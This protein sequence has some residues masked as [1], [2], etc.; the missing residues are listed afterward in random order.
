MADLNSTMSNVVNATRDGTLGVYGAL[1]Q[2]EIMNLT[3]FL[4]VSGSSSGNNG[5]V[6]GGN[7]VGCLNRF[8][9]QLGSALEEIEQYV[10]YRPE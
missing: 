2:E 9:S 5:T 1:F 10:S 4:S 6:S 3:D 7:N 8:C